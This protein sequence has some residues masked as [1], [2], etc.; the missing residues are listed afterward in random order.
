LGSPVAGE[1]SIRGR[2]PVER[3]CPDEEALK[4][5]PL[6]LS[7]SGRYVRDETVAAPA[8]C[9]HSTKARFL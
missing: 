5:G 7:I 9:P 3:W 4:P 6:G 8:A 1:R 2:G